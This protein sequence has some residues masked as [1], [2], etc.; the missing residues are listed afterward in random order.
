MMNE[1]AE[2]VIFIVK[3]SIEQTI[4]KSKIMRECKKDFFTKLA[5]YTIRNKV[6]I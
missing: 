6:S 2:F 3:K 1:S 5:G 4:R